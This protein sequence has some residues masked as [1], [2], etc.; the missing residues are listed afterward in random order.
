MKSITEQEAKEQVKQGKE[1][2]KK[3]LEDGGRI[4]DI[5]VHEKDK[6]IMTR[7]IEPVNGE[8]TSSTIVQEANEIII[9]P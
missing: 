2:F 8:A 4:T 1:G 6:T 5:T 3:I 7:K 9:N